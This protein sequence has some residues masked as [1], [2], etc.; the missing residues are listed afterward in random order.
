MPINRGVPL[1][2]GPILFWTMI[3]DIRPVEASNLIVKYANDIDLE[4]KLTDDSHTVNSKSRSAYMHSKTRIYD[5]S[6]SRVQKG[7][8]HL[9]DV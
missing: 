3:N 4:N 2:L 7:I 5:V 1:V 6:R 8:S 9:V